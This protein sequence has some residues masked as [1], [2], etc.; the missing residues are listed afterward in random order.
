MSPF[1]KG[2]LCIY[3]VVN[4][5]MDLISADHTAEV[6]SSTADH[7]SFCSV[8]WVDNGAN[9]MLGLDDARPGRAN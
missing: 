3:R 1:T 8:V 9:N 6:C 4:L 2:I 5:P 7:K